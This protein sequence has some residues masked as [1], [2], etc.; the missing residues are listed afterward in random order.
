MIGGAQVRNIKYV[1]KRINAIIRI[2]MSFLLI[3]T[4][5]GCSR[6]N[7]EVQ[8]DILNYINVELPKLVELESTV[9]EGYESVTGDNYTDDE[10]LYNALQNEIIPS[11]LDLIDAAEEIVPETEDVRVVHE[12]YLSAINKENSA[13]TTILSAIENQD[14]DKVSL[15]NDKLTDARKELRDFNSNLDDLA[16]DNDIEMDN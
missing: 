6:N 1:S 16:E 5:S 12:I 15:A 7:T 13:F 9:I 2:T 8:D 4:I 11:S 10:T 3:I 14:Y